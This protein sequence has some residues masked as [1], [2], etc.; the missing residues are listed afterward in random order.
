MSCHGRT[1]KEKKTGPD[2][3][4]IV[5]ETRYNSQ[6]MVYQTSLPYFD[7]IEAARY[8]T[9]A[10]DPLGR[11]TQT[12]NPD[13]TQATASYAGWSTTSVDANGHQRRETRDAFG[14]V[15]KVEEYTGT[16][17]TAT[18][19]ATT[20]YEYN[21]S[22]NLKSVTDEKGNKTSM[23]YDSLGRKLAMSDP[24]MGRCGDLTVLSPNSSFPWYPAP[25][26]NYEYDAGGNLIRQQD[27]KG[28]VILF[29]YDALNRLRQKDYGTQKT[30]GS[31]DVVYT[32]DAG[33]N[34]IGRLSQVS[35]LSG[36]SAFSY[37]AMGRSIQTD[38]IVGGTTFIT[39]TQYD[40]AGR[41]YAIAYPDN[42]DVYS[43]QY[44]YNGPVLKRVYEGAINHVQYSGHNGLG[45]SGTVSYANG[46][47][48]TYTYSN[49]GNST[50]PKDNYRLCTQRTVHGGAPAYQY[51]R[52]TYYNVGNVSQI[53]DNTDANNTQSF[54][55]DELNRLTSAQAT[56]YGTI[57]YTYNEIGNMM[58]NSQIGSYT[59]PTNGIRPHAV[60]TAGSNSYSYDDNGNMT[61]GAGRTIIYDYDNRPVS[62]TA[63][64]GTTTFLYDGAGNRVRKTAN[65]VTTVYIGKLYENTPDGCIKYIFAGDQRI[66]MRDATGAL[67]Y[68]HTDHL[69]SS[70]V[71]TDASGNMVER[72][73][74]F[75]YGQTRIN[76][77]TKDVHHKFTGQELDAET[78]LYFYGARY[79]DPLLGRFIQPD[80]IVPNLRN[81]QDLNRYSYVSNNPVNYIDPTGHSWFSKF[82]HNVNKELSNFFE[83]NNINVSAGVGESV[84]SGG[85]A[86][87]Y[88]YNPDTGETFPYMPISAASVN[89]ASLQGYSG[90]VS[91]EDDWVVDGVGGPVGSQQEFIYVDPNGMEF[92]N[93][94]GGEMRGCD[95]RGCG[96]Y[97]ASR[98][99][100]RG[101]G[102]H[103]SIDLISIPGQ[104]VFAAHGGTAFPYGSLRYPGVR[105]VG[106][107][108]TSE[109]LYIKATDAIRNEGSRG[110]TV[111]AGDVIGT[112]NDIRPIY[113]PRITNHIHF[114]LHQ[115]G[116][117][118]LIDPT[119]FIFPNR[120]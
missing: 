38:K 88:G 36:S 20:T 96:N 40:Y 116:S 12:T 74:Y 27:G 56:A 112:A 11:L 24:D 52:Y 57:S 117:T 10:H 61:S 15:I 33:T 60:T 53:I 105:I 63:G 71:V 75:P 94:T 109:T 111:N 92:V 31:G 16:S 93:P 34:G 22:G 87:S 89:T 106:D 30:I 55:Y 17:P 99:R 70:S 108:Y 95:Q 48:T 41:V 26:W 76:T 90:M 49:S 42:P 100:E 29:Q 65:G 97:E 119:S 4:V 44:E 73:A 107:R 64:G 3:K 77:G 91:S 19:Y 23:L 68:Y 18:L 43:V 72:L 7:G 45:Q 118:L 110:L 54:L 82:L 98:D 1:T 35:D 14:H 46:V 102:Y 47:T 79:Y 80:T 58:S 69:G 51:L 32:Y 103:L 67:F 39:K 9:F 59:Y 62:I 104:D 8:S 113:G 120:R 83:R 81:P 84:D 115:N 78:G 5:V 101:R 114:Q 85:R 28:Q 37:D 25:C 50:C 21:V 2:T 66:A 86:E 6:G 13:G